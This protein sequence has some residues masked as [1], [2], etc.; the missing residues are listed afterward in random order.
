MAT[1]VAVIRFPGTNCEFDVVEVVQ[2]LGAQAQIVFHDEPSLGSADAVVIAGGFAHGDYLR[3]GAIARFS[4]VMEAV[5]SFAKSGGPVVGICN[6]FQVLTEAN[7]LPG[8]LQK[9]ASLKFRCGFTDLRVENSNSV[10]TSEA[11]AGDI[12]SIPINHFEGN[13]TCS[14]ETL[15][16]LQGEDRVL[17]RYV[18]NPNGSV[19]DIAGICNEGRNVVGLMPHP[20]RAC[21]ELLGSR[22]GIVLMSS[23]LGAAGLNAAVPH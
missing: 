8:A 19:D 16:E 14:S 12:L 1:N 3:P 11:Q 10:L 5:A 18:T 13:Y 7:L 23:L 4:P 2:Q 9:N 20:E 22:D 21:H 17:F 6:G 15:A